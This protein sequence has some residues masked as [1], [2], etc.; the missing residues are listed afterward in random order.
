MP[1]SAAAHTDTV[2]SVDATQPAWTSDRS[3]SARKVGSATGTLP[4]LKA[5]ARPAAS[6]ASTAGQW[7]GGEVSVGG[8][9]EGE[10][11]QRIRRCGVRARVGGG[12]CDAIIRPREHPPEVQIFPYKSNT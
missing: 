12:G 11:M 1:A 9:G 8:G 6:T 7:V 5:I 2:V 10:A 4:T 3:R